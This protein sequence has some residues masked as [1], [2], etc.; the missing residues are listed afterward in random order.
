MDSVSLEGFEAFYQV[1]HQAVERYLQH[2][3]RDRDLA[4]DLAQEAFARTLAALPR[5]GSMS[6]A[7]VYRVATNCAIDELRRRKVIAWTTFSEVEQATGTAMSEVLPDRRADTQVAEWFAER[8]AVAQVLAHLAPEDRE[9]L[10][11]AL[12]HPPAVCARHLGTSLS[13][14]KMRLSRARHRAA[15]LRQQVAV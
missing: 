15:L 7:W 9:C 12:H 5:V 13:A 4:E 2:L 3:L 1:H 8:E 10:L 11:L 6:L 14:F